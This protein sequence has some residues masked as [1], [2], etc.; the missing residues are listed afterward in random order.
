MGRVSLVT[1]S[2][3]WC[4]GVQALGA[5]LNIDPFPLFPPPA[6]PSGHP[7]ACPAVV[8]G[9]QELE[10]QQP[11]HGPRS[12][13]SRH[14][15]SFLETAVLVS[16]SHQ[17]GPYSQVNPEQGT[18]SPSRGW[19]WGVGAI[20]FID[21]MRRPGSFFLFRVL[22]SAA[23]SRGAEAGPVPISSARSKVSSSE[24]ATC[25]AGGTSENVADIWG[26]ALPTSACSMEASSHP[27]EQAWS[28]GHSKAVPLGLGLW[29][30]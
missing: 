2:L 7:S 27:P 6:W 20:H 15:P 14:A 12:S 10:T 29:V 30:H 23:G 13:Q 11:P 9:Q 21:Q 19:V 24:Q 22:P 18:S 17:D 4:P 16:E 5:D 3:S 1:T 28:H 8:S 26:H 25:P